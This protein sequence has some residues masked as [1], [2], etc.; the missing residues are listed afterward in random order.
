MSK[1]IKMKRTYTFKR[2]ILIICAGGEER[3]DFYGRFTLEKIK[4]MNYK[5]TLYPT[6][7]K[8]LSEEKL[9]RLASQI[10][11]SGK[12]TIDTIFVSHS[13][14]NIRDLMIALQSHA[15]SSSMGANIYSL[16]KEPLTSN[17]DQISFIAISLQGLENFMNYENV[18]EYIEDC[19]EYDSAPSLVELLQ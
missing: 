4:V 11:S 15:T 7:R 18:L 19:S 9:K 1:L 8:I 12:G 13:I 3:T 10:L 14:G 17:F 16:G 2:R 5:V 6:T